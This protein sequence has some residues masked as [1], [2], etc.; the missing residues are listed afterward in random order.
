MN[1]KFLLAPIVFILLGA[2]LPARRAQAA[3]DQWTANWYAQTGYLLPKEGDL[4]GAALAG[5]GLRMQ[6]NNETVFAEVLASETNARVF[7]NSGV[8]QTLVNIGYMKPVTRGKR[9][10]FGFGYQS[11]QIDFGFGGKMTQS[12]YFGNLDYKVSRKISVRALSSHRTQKNQVKF[13]V[14]ILSIIYDF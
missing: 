7:I 8:N 2:A 3:E 6:L 5:A 10:Q 4:D 11:Q 14:F 1:R 12:T 13:G 9:L